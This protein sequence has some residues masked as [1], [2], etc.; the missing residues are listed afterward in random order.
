MN[1]DYDRFL[2]DDLTESVCARC[3]TD[4]N[5]TRP[6]SLVHDGAFHGVIVC[7]DGFR[8][9][10]VGPDRFEALAARLGLVP[11]IVEVEGSSLFCEV[12]AP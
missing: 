11:K 7:E 2:V 4:R 3:G 9:T 10:T 12:V 1:P 5:L 8:A 6:I